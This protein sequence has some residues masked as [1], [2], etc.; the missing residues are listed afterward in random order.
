MTLSLHSR[1]KRATLWILHPLPTPICFCLPS[2]RRWPPSWS[3][4]PV[5]SV[6]PDP[7]FGL[8]H[9]MWAEWC[10]T[11]PA[12]LKGYYGH[13]RLL[14]QH[15]PPGCTLVGKDSALSTRGRGRGGTRFLQNYEEWSPLQWDP[16]PSN[17][18]AWQKQ[19][20][21]PHTTLPGGAY[22]SSS[23]SALLIWRPRGSKALPPGATPR[24]G[25]VRLTQKA[26]THS[27]SRLI[28]VISSKEFWN[29]VNQSLKTVKW[30]D[31]DG[32]NIPNVP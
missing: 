24:A 6:R 30:R 9:R 27:T 15:L 5:H 2:G 25:L 10:A 31:K 13:A 7:G 26:L 17:C 14:P 4:L 16:C 22:N 12:C 23:G 21:S 28:K 20:R 32:R 18:H 11:P 1:K 8:P 29:Q 19:A 3:H